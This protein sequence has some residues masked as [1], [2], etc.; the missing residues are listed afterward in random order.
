M[1]IRLCLATIFLLTVAACGGATSIDLSEPAP[2]DPHERADAAVA[3]DAA[4]SRPTPS[5]PVCA[6]VRG[7]C[8][9]QHAYDAC[10]ISATQ[11]CYCGETQTGFEWACPMINPNG[12]ACPAAAPKSGAACKVAVSCSYCGQAAG[13]GLDTALC[14][15]GTWERAQGNAP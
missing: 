14:N 10:R 9:A 15:G 5:D 2:S 6:P 13:S 1:N 4:V 8:D 12:S 3:E 7:M 11:C